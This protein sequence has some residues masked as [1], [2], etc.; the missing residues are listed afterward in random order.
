MFSKWFQA[1]RDHT[2]A[3]G[4]T[5][6][7][8]PT[9]WVWNKGEKQWKERQQ[10]MRI[11]RLKYAHPNSGER[12]Y[13][14]MLLTKVQGAKCYEDIRTVNGVVY[15][16]FKSA[17]LALGLLDDDNEWGAALTEASTWASGSQLRNLF[18]SM[19]MFSEVTNPLELWENH[20]VDLTDDLQNR[21]RRLTGD[22]N[23]SLQE[24]DLKNLGLVEIEKI[25]NQNGRSQR[26]FS[27]MPFPSYRDAEIASN[28][29]I[30]EELQYDS[31]LEMQTFQS[32]HGGLNEDQLRVFDTIVEAHVSRRGGLFFVYGSGGTG[33]TYLWKT[34]IAKFRAENK[35]VLSVASSG[36]SALFKWQGIWRETLCAWWGFQTNTT[37]YYQ[38]RSGTNGGC[39]FT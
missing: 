4:L 32:L 30:R 15:P 12:Y 5:F 26:E 38:R 21:V 8:V 31:T 37:R 17:C 7:E 39:F 28:K 35:I 16:T 23:V 2:S 24:C 3:N 25:L 1:N 34:L 6:Q 27:P 13:L 22:G 14:R 10:Q 36:I 29:L 20:W 9:L 19:L 18:C 11:G 33:K